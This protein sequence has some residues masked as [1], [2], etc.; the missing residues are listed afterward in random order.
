MVMAPGVALAKLDPDNVGTVVVAAALGI[1][2]IPV[3]CG[4]LYALL[5]RQRSR[6]GRKVLII[7]P[8]KLVTVGPV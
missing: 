8:A 5:N 4:F 7:G 1:L 6:T 3:A 2:T